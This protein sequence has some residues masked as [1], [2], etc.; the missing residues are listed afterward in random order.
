MFSGQGSQYFNMGKSLYESDTVFRHQLTSLNNKILLLTQ[1]DVLNFLFQAD[2]KT[3][4]GFDNPVVA[5]LAIFLLEVA[6]VKTLD[7]YGIAADIYL[8]SSFGTIVASLLA[9]RV[10]EDLAIKTIFQHSNIFLKNTLPGGM[11]A[12]LGS[13]NI[14]EEHERLAKITQIAAIHLDNAFVLATPAQHLEETMGILT[15]MNIPYQNIFCSRAYHS[16]W[17]DGARPD[18]LSLY[19]TLAFSPA[20]IPVICTSHLGIINPVNEKALWRAVREPMCFKKIITHL[21][22]DS[23]HRYIDIGPSGSLGMLLKYILPKAPSHTATP[24]STSTILLSPMGGED[25]RFA[26]FLE[27]YALEN[28]SAPENA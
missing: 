7:K 21:E 13:P 27:N 3:G 20:A 1:I 10:D 28:I 24:S 6:M 18:F 11:I 8:G 16:E 14:H 19:E 25:K 12:V 23:A 5:G 22:L 2:K 15:K 4:E 17:I 9:G 26:S